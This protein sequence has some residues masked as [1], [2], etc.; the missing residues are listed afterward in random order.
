[1]DLSFNA[2]LAAQVFHFLLLLVLMRIFA[3]RPLLKVLDDRRRMVA[4]QLATA[5]RDREEAGDLLRQRQE[6]LVEAREQARAIIDRA[7][8]EAESRV[9]RILEQARNDS[10]AVK[11]K[12]L[13]ALERERDEARKTLRDELAE[14]VLTATQKVAG[15]MIDRE[16]HLRLVREAVKEVGAQRCRIQE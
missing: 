4:E 5:E 7:E 1:M 13:A 16:Q 3:Y 9:R 8:S 14:L 2:T 15:R 10:D 6:M 12:A 11:N